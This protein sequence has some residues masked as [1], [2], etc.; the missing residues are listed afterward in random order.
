MSKKIVMTVNIVS[1]HVSNI[2]AKARTEVP[3][4]LFVLVHQSQRREEP[5]FWPAETTRYQPLDYC[6][7]PKKILP[8][9]AFR[10]YTGEGCFTWYFGGDFRS[11]APCSQTM[12][13]KVNDMSAPYP[14]A[15]VNSTD[16]ALSH[17]V[18]DYHVP[19]ITAGN[20]LTNDQTGAT[21]PVPYAAMQSLLN[22]T[23]NGFGTA[24][25][26]VTANATALANHDPV[27]SGYAPGELIG[28]ASGQFAGQPARL[29]HQY[30]LPEFRRTVAVANG[31]RRHQPPGRRHSPRRHANPDRQHQHGVCD[32]GSARRQQPAAARDP[33]SGIR[34]RPGPGTQCQPHGRWGTSSA[35]TLIRTSSPRWSFRRPHQRAS[36]HKTTQSRAGGCID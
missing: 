33:G 16:K 29:L 3:R 23:L 2:A 13:S 1:D 25:Y 5:E 19:I 12:G 20:F 26:S 30:G 4:L 35:V 18:Y 24:T 34:Y 14:G 36:L 6:P 32:H 15:T 27:I 21:L 10:R 7:C 11:P 31:S 28:G 8:R 9:S 22:L 17:V